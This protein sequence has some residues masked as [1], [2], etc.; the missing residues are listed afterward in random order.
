VG[1][2]ELTAEAAG[3]FALV[4]ALCGT[5]LLTPAGVAP[6]AAALAAG[7]IIVAM[8]A[9]FSPVSGA[10]FNPAITLGLIAAG[11]LDSSRA[12]YLILGQ[13]VGGI[14]AAAVLAF[15]VAGAAQ[16]PRGG[17]STI[18]NTYGGAFGITAVFAVEFVATALLVLIVVGMGGRRAPPTLA[19]LAIGL[20][21]ASLY[22][23]AI[24]VSGGGLNP[25]RS[26]AVAPFA[27]TNAI[28][29]LWVFWVAPILGA[30]LGGV[31]GRFLSDE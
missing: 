5:Q 20:T 27:G 12:P 26:L 11:R 23:I 1:A 22:L 6:L 7:G 30:I 10:H 2:R 13:C 31:L 9:A 15:V 24:P 19:P 14:A 18:A 4:L 29:Q 21:T 3:T 16:A 8:T 17:L 28:L 25:A